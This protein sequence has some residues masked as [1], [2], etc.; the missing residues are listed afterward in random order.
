MRYSIKPRDRIYVKGYGFLSFSKN[1]GRNLSNNTVKIDSAKES[2][3]N[4][5]KTASKKA[6]QNIA[7]ATGELIDNKI[8]DKI[9]SVWKTSAK[10]LQ[11][12]ETDVERAIPKKR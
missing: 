8:P 2:T 4:A 11:N 7:E 6:I 12:D 9:T 5:I 10:T 1:M 3:T